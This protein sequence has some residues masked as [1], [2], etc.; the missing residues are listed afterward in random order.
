M[1]EELKR[2]DIPVEYTWDIKSMFKDYNEW[3]EMHDKV[4]K[5]ANEF[6]SYK[7]T[8]TNSSN[9][10]LK[11]IKDYETMYRNLM[12][13]YSFASMNLDI[14]TRDSTAQALESK[15]VSLYTKVSEKSS[16]V[17]PMILESDED[18]IKGY[19]EEN[20][21]LS[22]Y[23]QFF[24]NIFRGKKHVLSA[25]EEAIMAQ[26]SEIGTASSNTFSML[27]NA[28][29]K[30]PKIKDEDGNEVEITH[31]NFIPFMES[32][33]RRIR[34]DAFEALYSVYYDHKNTLASTLSGEI[35][36]NIFKSKMRGYESSRHAS[37]HENNI[38]VSVYDNLIESIHDNL[39]K[40]YKYMD[41]RKKVLGVEEL[42]MYD[43]YTPIVSDV[44]FKFSYDE[45]VEVIK[46][47]L[48]PLG[49]EYVSAM[50]EGFSSRWVD[51]YETR[52][53]R[54]GAYSGGSY[55]SHPFILL[56]Y[57]DTLDNVFTT[58]HEMGHSMHSYLT[59]KYQPFIYGNYSIFLAEV[60]STTN[61]LLLLNYM[62]ENTSDENEKLYLLNHYIESFRTTVFRQTMFAEF[63]MIIN[64]FVE[65]GGALTS[66][67]L[68][69]TYS[70][71]NKKYY[72]PN[73]VVDEQIGIEWARIPHFYY[74]FYVFQYATGFSCA[75]DFS[76]KIINKEPGA[77]EKYL[78]FLKSGSSDYAINIL[79][80]AGVDMTTKEP[81]DNGMK[82]FGKLVDDFAELI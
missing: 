42:H 62:L 79:Q 7:E 28:D 52:G 75:V 73:V 49:E 12:N 65:E 24:D 57:K 51:V 16:F 70:D 50:E 41:V 46:K 17:T 66:D 67:Y 82:L 44:D 2:E 60:A 8:L 45:G 68:C 37:L 77:V 14:D 76:T 58:A 72:G 3:N 6:E 4:E 20:E 63:E 81:V 61:E 35:K 11:G 78:E 59:R 25:R 10:L 15:A 54:S 32:K 80:K 31:G 30:F 48:Q 38:P 69:S 21:E 18:I 36:A 27:N 64:R 23:K 39:D 74:N 56:N 34:K 29:L 33:N 53:K 22:E 1:K 19:L 5:L 9:D 47:A 55:D 40:M 26:V 43:I 71:L 13:L